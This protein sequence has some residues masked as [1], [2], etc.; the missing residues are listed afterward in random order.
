MSIASYLILSTANAGRRGLCVDVCK[1]AF[2]NLK[3]KVFLS[4]S[5][6]PCDDDEKLDALENVEIIKYLSLNDAFEKLVSLDESSTDIILFVA[7]SRQSIADEVENFKSVVDT[8]KIRLARIWG[9]IDCKMYEMFAKKVEGFVEAV[10]HFSDCVL[11]SQ[12]SGVPNSVVNELIANFNKQCKPHLIVLMD[13]HNSVQN[14]FEIT[15][16]ETRRISMLFDEYD[17]ADELDLD[18]ENLPEEPFSLERK[19][20][21]YLEKLQDGHRKKTIPN[22]FEFARLAHQ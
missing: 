22:V 9:I 18:E 14:T 7:S 15:I 17:P 13:K 20:D 12:R 11:L 8:G 19:P 5:E 16:E 2:E 6:L 3:V 1:N 4:T 21:P 10:S